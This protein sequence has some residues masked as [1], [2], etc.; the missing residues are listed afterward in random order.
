MRWLC[1]IGIVDIITETL[2]LSAY[3]AASRVRHLHQTLH[4]FKYM[5]DHKCF[6]F[7]FEPN[8]VDITDDHMPVEEREI[9]REKFINELYP[10]L[11]E[12]F[13]LNAPN[14]KSVSCPNILFC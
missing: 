1:E 14:A 3:L 13:P 5:K 2:L 8:Y 11:V 6:K 9:Y 10:N 7:V 4:V 12:Y